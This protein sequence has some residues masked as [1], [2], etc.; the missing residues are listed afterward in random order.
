MG[1]T[2]RRGVQAADEQVVASMKINAS[3]PQWVKDIWPDAEIVP[4]GEL[5]GLKP[6]E[7]PVMPVKQKSQDVWQHWEESG[8]N[9]HA[10]PGG[11]EYGRD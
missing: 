6:R 1:R 5:M 9:P 4:D 10:K 3:A 2:S 11:G 7:Q 8:I